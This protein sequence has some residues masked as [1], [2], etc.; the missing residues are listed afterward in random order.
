MPLLADPQR[1]EIAFFFFLTTIPQVNQHQ[2]SLYCAITFRK[3]PASTFEFPD[4]STALLDGLG[5]IKAVATWHE[6]ALLDSRAKALRDKAALPRSGKEA[7]WLHDMTL[8][9]AAIFFGQ[10]ACARNDAL[11]YCWHAGELRF[12]IGVLDPMLRG[13]GV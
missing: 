13:R 3:S 4:I 6:T 12:F 9:F 1:H 2:A 7:Q 8:A 11:A 10:P 5:R